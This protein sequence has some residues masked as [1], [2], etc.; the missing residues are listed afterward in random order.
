MSSICGDTVL[1]FNHVAVR[2]EKRERFAF[3]VV[4]F[5]WLQDR[6]RE[7]VSR[8]PGANVSGSTRL[9]AVTNRKL[10]TQPRL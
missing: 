7:V 9:S 4:F 10:A 8:Y 5:G 6:T 2:M 3:S 1:S